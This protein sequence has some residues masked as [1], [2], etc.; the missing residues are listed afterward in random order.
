MGRRGRI[1]A[2]AFY[3]LSLPF[4]LATYG[5]ARSEIYQEDVFGKRTYYDKNVEG[6]AAV[7]GLAVTVGMVG[8]GSVVLF[9]SEERDRRR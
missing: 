6:G 3:L 9:C 8:I 5:V 1:V 2:G 4:G 7:T